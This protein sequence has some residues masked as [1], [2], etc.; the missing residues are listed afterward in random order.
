MWEDLKFQFQKGNMVI[1]LI[2]VNVTIHFLITLAYIPFYLIFGKNATGLTETYYGFFSEWFY[3]PSDLSKLVFRPW[4]V[5]TYMFLHSSVLHLFFNMLMLYWFG[6]IMGD[7]INNTRVLP[8]YLMAGLFGGLLFVSAYNIFPVFDGYKPPIL[9][10]SASV[11][12]IVIA[13][14]TL[15]PKGVFYVFLLGEIQLRYIAL[16]LFLLDIISIPDGNAGGRIAHIGGAIMGWYFV[17]A[18]R[19]GLDFSKPI[20]KVIYFISKPF[21]RNTLIHNSYKK[22]SK[23]V[24][25]VEP[26]PAQTNVY[27]NNTVAKPH[28]KEDF[29]PIFKG[30]SRNFVQEY[31]HLTPQGCVDAILDKIRKNGFNSISNEEKSFLDMMSKG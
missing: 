10:A 3:L 19:S 11:M 24:Y 8:I 20:N 27:A 25:K 16:A 13:T 31:Q 6:K 12:G 15:N 2:F 7:L 18:L 23:P 1:K 5:L 21:Q 9:G 28:A 29:N 17:I 30:Y 22:E 4:T 26:Q 14:A